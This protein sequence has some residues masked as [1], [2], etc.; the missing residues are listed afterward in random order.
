MTTAAVS[1]ATASSGASASSGAPR[2]QLLLLWLAGP[3]LASGVVAWSRYDGNAA[4]RPAD[5]LPDG[6]PYPSALAAMRDGWRVLGIAPAPTSQPGHELRTGFLPN[7]IILE[8][9]ESAH[10]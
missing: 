7:E 1:G 2:Q 8:R 5:D 9:L 4:E 6:P 3:D 10:V